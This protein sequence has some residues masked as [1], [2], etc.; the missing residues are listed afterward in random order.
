[1]ISG[2]LFD[3]VTSSVTI[4]NFLKNHQYISMNQKIEGFQFIMA[5]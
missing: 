5:I 2:T 1:M 4:S 3:N